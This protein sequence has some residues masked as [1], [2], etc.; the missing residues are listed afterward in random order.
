MELIVD[1]NIV[2]KSVEEKDAASLFHIVMKNLERFKPWFGWVH[3]IDSVQPIENFVKAC[4]NN[5]D[6]VGYASMVIFYNNQPV[7]FIGHQNYKSF[8][9]SLQLGYWLDQAHEG[10]GVMTKSVIKMIDYAFELGMN[11]VE[12]YCASDNVRSRKIPERLGFTEEG[13]IRA[14]ELIND[15]YLDDVVYGVLKD[16]WIKD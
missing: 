15:V 16:E 3:Q 8:N 7:G 2:L 13:T 1:E 6:K 14:A 10:K 12:I 11:K 9:K 4:I 5:E